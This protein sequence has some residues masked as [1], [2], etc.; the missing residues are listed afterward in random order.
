[1]LKTALLEHPHSN[2]V[3]WLDES[4]KASES[5]R[6]DGFVRAGGYDNAGKFYEVS[7]SVN[8]GGSVKAGI[9][10]GASESPDTDYSA[11]WP[12]D[13]LGPVDAGTQAN[14]WG[15]VERD[16]NWSIGK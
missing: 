2:I 14:V 16:L 10:G 15:S 3:F 8:A 7:G 6:A 5:V 9:Y 13:F 1:M 12:V 11:G 4:V